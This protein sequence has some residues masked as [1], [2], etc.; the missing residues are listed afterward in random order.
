MLIYSCHEIFKNLF[1]LFLLKGSKYLEAVPLFTNTA[2]SLKEKCQQLKQIKKC[3]W[4][5]LQTSNFPFHK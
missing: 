4:E 1:A 5:V 3:T 2:S